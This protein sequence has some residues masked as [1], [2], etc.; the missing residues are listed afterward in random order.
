MV[1]TDYTK[2]IDAETWAFIERTNSFYP[3]ETVHFTIPEQREVYG[4]LCRAFFAGYPPDVEA[5]TTEFRT[6]DHAIPVR[7]YKATALPLQDPV[8]AESPAGSRPSP[9]IVL[10]FHG[11]GLV[12]GYLRGRHTV[13]RAQAS[14]SRIVEAVQA[15]G[16]GEWPY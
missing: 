9:P 1:I 13:G 3:P 14:F 7:I 2:L 5:E 10:Y 15:L 16:A 6:G 12:H 11:G 8:G 4:D